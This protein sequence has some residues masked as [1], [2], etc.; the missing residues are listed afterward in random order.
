LNTGIITAHLTRATFSDSGAIIGAV[1]GI[2]STKYDRFIRKIKPVMMAVSS[3][4]AI[5]L[6]W[7]V[8]QNLIH[9][10]KR[11]ALSPYE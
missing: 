5:F 7:K 2:R 1:L 4:Q 11:H 8:Q 9:A 3:F 10:F 6:P